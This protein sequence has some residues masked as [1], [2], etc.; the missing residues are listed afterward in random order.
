MPLQVKLPKAT[1]LKMLPKTNR[2]YRK[3][4]E[5]KQKKACGDKKLPE[6]VFGNSTKESL[7]KRFQRQASDNKRPLE[8]RALMH[9]RILMSMEKWEESIKWFLG[10]NL[11]YGL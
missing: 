6:K 2:F 5:T 10:V 4:L 9:L 7:T 11:V 1:T 3:S 8:K